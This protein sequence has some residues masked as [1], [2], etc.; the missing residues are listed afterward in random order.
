VPTPGQENFRF[1]LWLFQSS[2]PV[3]DQP[4]EV[5]VNDFAYYPLLAGDFNKNASVDASD[6]VAWRNGLGTR[7]EASDYDVW[8]GNFGHAAGVGT[9]ADVSVPE[10]SAAAISIAAVCCLMCVVGRTPRFD[11]DHTCASGRWA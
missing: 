11:V 6:Y 2:A 7:Y 1:N 5:V 10:P 9:F 3:G 4:V 8:R